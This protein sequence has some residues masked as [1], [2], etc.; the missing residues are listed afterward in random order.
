MVV[1][2]LTKTFDSAFGDVS[3]IVCN[4]YAVN[5]IHFILCFGHMNIMLEWKFNC[6]VDLSWNGILRGIDDVTH[7]CNLWESRMSRWI[8]S[9]I[10]PTNCLLYKLYNTDVGRLFV[11]GLVGK[12]IRASKRR[13]RRSGIIFLTV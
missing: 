8:I 2:C 12:W 11:V 5:L 4:I 1:M 7:A 3:V 9:M 6:E 13:R 10:T